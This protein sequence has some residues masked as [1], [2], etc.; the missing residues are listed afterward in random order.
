MSKKVLS[1]ALWGLEAQ[2]IEVESDLGGGELGV[3]SIVGLPDKSVYESRE[4]V[5]S[6]IK[7][8]GL[9][10]PQR[11]VLVNLAPADFKKQGPSYDLPIAISVLSL[12]SDLKEDFS[13]SVFLGELALN[14]D[15]R[16]ING[17]LALVSY[18]KSKNIKKVYL[19]QANAAEAS[20]IDGVDVFPVNNL[21]ELYLHLLNKKEIKAAKKIQFNFTNKKSKYDMKDIKGQQQAKRALEIA[22]AGSHNILMFGP[23]GSGKTLLAKTLVSILPDL[24]LNEA[25]EITKIYSVAACLEDRSL[26]NFRPFRSPHHSASLVSVLGG[27]SWPRPGEISLAHRGVL[28]LDELGEFSRFLLDNLRQPI[29]DGVIN[30]SRSAQ[31]LS[32]PARFMLVAAMNPCPCG[33]FGDKDKKCLCTAAQLANYNKKI[34]GPIYDRI[35]IFIEVPRVNFKNLSDQAN[36]ESSESIKKRVEKARAIQRQ[37]FRLDN[38]F[39]NS[40]MSNELIKKFCQIDQASEK[41]L[42]K[43]VEKINLSNRA[44]FK[45]LKIARTI[46]DLRGDENI[47]FSDIAEALQYKTPLS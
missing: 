35:D 8:L 18:L 5:R 30:I 43:A 3:F 38:I 33:Y 29:E 45:I 12:I 32:F 20:L 4:R 39:S 44:Y 21:K 7:S 6:A 31:S 19:P 34:S 37:R 28:F 46:A 47:S 41:L 17:V 27:G 9:K 23:P 26:I 40:E 25:L 11:K 42:Q 22:A 15:L 16:K 1:L 24:N 36:A 13:Q 10:F 2:L 14:G